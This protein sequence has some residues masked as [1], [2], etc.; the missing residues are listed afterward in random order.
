M[1]SLPWI[2]PSIDTEPKYVTESKA[3]LWWFRRTVA[4]TQV[5]QDS[6]FLFLHRPGPSPS[7]C[8]QFGAKR[9]HATRLIVFLLA[10][11]PSSDCKYE[12]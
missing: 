3:E 11:C 9:H 2:Q 4:M 6:V 12:S 10:S 8:Y 1:E 7:Q 5:N